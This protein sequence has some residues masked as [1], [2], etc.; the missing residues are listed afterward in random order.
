MRVDRTVDRCRYR[1]RLS[2]SLCRNGCEYCGESCFLQCWALSLSCSIAL[3]RRWLSFLSIPSCTNRFP[4]ESNNTM[5]HVRDQRERG[6]HHRIVYCRMHRSGC[7]QMH[8][9]YQMHRA[10]Y[11]QMHWFY[12]AHWSE[13]HHMY[14]HLWHSVRC[15]S[16]ID[17][18]SVRMDSLSIENISWRHQS[19]WRSWNWDRV[20]IIDM[21]AYRVDQPMVASHHHA[22]RSYSHLDVSQLDD[23]AT[24]RRVVPYTRTYWSVWWP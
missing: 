9:H 24:Y 23:V 16:S 20:R 15:H 3:H 11:H 22:D 8:R 6:M 1:H 4:V 12:Q 21:W 7:H 2:A 13:Y 18:S 17:E 5:T 10:W 14:Y 19:E